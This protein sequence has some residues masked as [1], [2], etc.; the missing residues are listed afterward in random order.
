MTQIHHRELADNAFLI[1]PRISHIIRADLS[2]NSGIELGRITT[3]VVDYPQVTLQ[4]QFL[5][6]VFAHDKILGGPSVEKNH[7]VFNRVD[8]LFFGT[9]HQVA[10]F[11]RYDV[12]LR[13]ETDRRPG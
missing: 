7:T 10:C 13:A 2:E 3:I 9:Q 1:P 11:K 8:D 5:G 6:V 4:N 12:R